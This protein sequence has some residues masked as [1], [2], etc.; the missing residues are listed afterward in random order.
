ME[1]CN[2]VHAG[3]RIELQVDSPEQVSQLLMRGE[4][5]LALKYT[6]APEPDM[7]A[8]RQP[9]SIAMVSSTVSITGS[10]ASAGRWRSLPLAASAPTSAVAS[11]DPATG[12][13]G[14]APPAS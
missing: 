4:A 11:V 14:R 2:H 6:V 10:S 8:S 9:G 1:A 7:R 3:S 13:I 5:D 12:G